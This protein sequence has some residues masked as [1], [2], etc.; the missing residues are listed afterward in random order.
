MKK[1]SVSVGDKPPFSSG[2][3]SL[4]YPAGVKFVGLASEWAWAEKQKNRDSDPQQCNS[5]EDTL[6]NT[7]ATV[8]DLWAATGR[9]EEFERS[10]QSCLIFLERHL[11]WP[12][13]PFDFLELGCANGW[14]IRWM[15]HNKKHATKLVG[16]DVS[17]G[18]IKKATQCYHHPPNAQFIS[19]DLLDFIPESPFQVV[20][21][22]ATLYYVVP[23][24]T[25]APKIKS[26]VRPGGIF[27]AG[28]DCRTENSKSSEW[29]KMLGVKMDIRDEKEWVKLFAED[30]GLESVGQIVIPNQDQEVG[31]LFTWGYLPE[32]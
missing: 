9:D 10:N 12:S 31:T 2:P 1:R 18:M 17:Q 4:F 26:W 27:I 28:T 19:S 16:I 5:R 14:A 32:V 23:M 15:S 30:F 22:M 8:F 6:N 7:P 25:I 21:S 13:D 3:S 11:P 24:E 20:Y 29:P